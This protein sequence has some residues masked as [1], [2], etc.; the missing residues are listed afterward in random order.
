LHQLPLECPPEDIACPVEPNPPRAAEELKLELEL[1]LELEFELEPD[2][3]APLENALTRPPLL[4]KAVET[5][6]EG[7]DAVRCRRFEFQ[8][9]SPQER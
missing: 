8:L 4:V 2:D 3:D 7:V 6:L 5:E 9:Q 1:E